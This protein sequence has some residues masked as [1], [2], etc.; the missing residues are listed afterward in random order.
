MIKHQYDHDYSFDGFG[1]DYESELNINPY[2]SRFYEFA[3]A[4]RNKNRVLVAILS[5]TK[6]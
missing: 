3:L 4:K 6:K 2:L 1:Y 5:L